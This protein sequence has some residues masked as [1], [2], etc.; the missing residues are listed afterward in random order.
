MCGQPAIIGFARKSLFE[1]S[2]E[3]GEARGYEGTSSL[4]SSDSRMFSL[5]IF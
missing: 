5:A 1:G 2:N 4:P 3:Q